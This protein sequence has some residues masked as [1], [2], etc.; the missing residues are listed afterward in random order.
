M[1]KV[2]IGHEDVFIGQT[3]DRDCKTFVQDTIPDKYYFY[4]NPRWVANMNQIK[5]IAI[6]K[7]KAFPMTF[8]FSADIE[9]SDGNAPPN[10]LTHNIAHAFNEN[11]T[12]MNI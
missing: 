3:Y 7:I 1:S 4:Y 2:R 10:R 6:R 9:F 12:V 8:V 5:R 11:N